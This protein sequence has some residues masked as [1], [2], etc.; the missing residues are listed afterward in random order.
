MLLSRVNSV[1]SFPFMFSGMG[2]PGS[3]NG[4]YTAAPSDHHCEESQAPVVPFG[5]KCQ[6]GGWRSQGVQALSSLPSLCDWRDSGIWLISQMGRKR[7][8]GKSVP[9]ESHNPLSSAPPPLSLAVL[10]PLLMLYLR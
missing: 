3:S 8:I 4:V 7:H 6:V 5:Q 2:G 10:A 1:Q 9:S